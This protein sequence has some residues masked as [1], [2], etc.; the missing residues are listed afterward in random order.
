MRDARCG[1]CLRIA[2]KRSTN[3]L[4]AS[5]GDSSRSERPAAA[6]PAVT[7][8]RIAARRRR[9]RPEDMGRSDTSRVRPRPA[10]PRKRASPGQLAV[11]APA[12]PGN[13]TCTGPNWA[14]RPPGP[15]E[16]EAAPGQAGRGDFGRDK[17]A[18]RATT[19]NRRRAGWKLGF[20]E[21]GNMGIRWPPSDRRPQLTVT[22]CVRGRTNLLE[23]G[24]PSGR[25]VPGPSRQRP[26]S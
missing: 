7:R 15:I 9:L 2:R 17:A 5:P 12:H 11:A 22:T 24:R 20:I 16:N 8:R 19:T 1:Q 26:R 21:P 4:P 10:Q 6:L 18:S 14:R 23:M 13:W 3:R 25:T